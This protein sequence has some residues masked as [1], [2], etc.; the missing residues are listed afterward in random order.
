VAGHLEP[1]S[2]PEP[3]H[4]ALKSNGHD[5]AGI[6]VSGGAG[7]AGKRTD[8]ISKG[9]RDFIRIGFGSVAGRAHIEW[10][11]FEIVDGKEKLVQLQW[12]HAKYAQPKTTMPCSYRNP[13][14]GMEWAAATP[15][16]TGYI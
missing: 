14:S 16:S 3:S 7:T 11:K 15:T 5:D 8:T 4:D 9:G 1:Q 6:D 10:G 2:S 13:P 12:S